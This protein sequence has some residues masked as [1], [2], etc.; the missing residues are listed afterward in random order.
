MP[1]K[2]QR[3]ENNN[4]IGD[5]CDPDRDGDGIPN[6]IDNCPDVYNPSQNYTTDAKDAYGN[7]LGDACNPNL[8]KD[9]SVDTD[10]DGVPDWLDNCPEVYNPDQSD[11]NHN[12]IGDACDWDMDGDGVANSRDNCEKVYNPDQADSDHDGVGDACSNRFCYK[13]DNSDTCMDPTLAFT[14]ATGDLS[15]KTGDKLALTFWANREN[16]S[17]QYSWSVVTRPE[18]SNATISNPV[19]SSSLSTPYNYH[20]ETG[21]AVEFTPDMPGTY[22]IQMNAKLVFPDAQYPDVQT[23]STSMSLTASGSPVGSGCSTAA[24]SGSMVGLLGLLLG[25]IGLKLRRS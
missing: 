7:P 18:G 14:V 19:G 12:G 2:D 15:A 22:G 4:G 11:I 3:D 8:P 17:I 9:N 25:L 13:V 20:Y 21:R 6:E 16:A 5:A 24:G 10:K 23:A 1:N